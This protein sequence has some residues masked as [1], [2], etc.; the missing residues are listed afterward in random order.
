MQLKDTDPIAY[1]KKDHEIFL[2]NS[3]NGNVFNTVNDFVYDCNPLDF[4][5][6]AILCKMR[7]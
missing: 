7:V 1:F 6:S 2:I 5:M 3:E 4:D